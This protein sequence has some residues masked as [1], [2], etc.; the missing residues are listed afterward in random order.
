MFLLLIHL[1]DQHICLGYLLIILLS[2]RQHPNLTIAVH[3][4]LAQHMAHLSG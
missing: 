1:I 4:F 3:I 2:L